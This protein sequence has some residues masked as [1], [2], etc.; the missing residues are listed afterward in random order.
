MA[1]TLR[2]VRLL[3]IV[4]WLGGLI[5]FAFIEA[6]AAFH[7]MGTTREF[8]L[9]IQSSIAGINYTGYVA[10]LLLL[11]AGFL[12]QRGGSVRDRKLIWAEMLLVALM[13]AAIAY[14]QM[15]VVPAMTRDRIS[16]GGDINSV[17]ADNPTRAH[18][19]SLHAASEQIEGAA[20]FLGIAV[21]LL[22]AAEHGGKHMAADEP[23]SS[24]TR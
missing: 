13:I 20:L 6:P 11:L 9:L 10:G 23:L 21:V 4:V 14:V 22:M 24:P 5:F 16:V 2:A 18:F 12:L 3:A 15:H 7:A 17:P 8:A 1:Y 19:D